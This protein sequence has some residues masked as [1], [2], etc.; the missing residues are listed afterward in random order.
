MGGKAASFSVRSGAQRVGREETEIESRAV[1]P[2]AHT[3]VPGNRSARFAFS[4]IPYTGSQ[5]C[6]VSGFF[7][8]LA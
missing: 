4:R 3:A 8:G 1:D 7:L 5:P 6:A 2:S